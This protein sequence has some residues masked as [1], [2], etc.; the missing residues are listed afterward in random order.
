MAYFLVHSLASSLYFSLSV[1]YTRAI[2]GTKG[3]SGLASVSNEQIDSN[4]GN[5]KMHNVECSIIEH[6]QQRN[7]TYK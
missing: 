3:S 1:L 6:Q 7:D 5:E 4:T 2:S